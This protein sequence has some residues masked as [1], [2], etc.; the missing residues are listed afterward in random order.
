MLREK[1]IMYENGKFWV[2]RTKNSYEVYEIGITHSL[3]CDV[4][5]RSFPNALD[6]AK[7]TC[8]KRQANQ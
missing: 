6:R 5:G 2:L 4:I 1:D 7:Q 8:D 3:R